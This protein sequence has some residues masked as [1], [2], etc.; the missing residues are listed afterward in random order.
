MRQVERCEIRI[1]SEQAKL[2]IQFYCLLET[3]KNALITIMDDDNLTAAVS[4][5]NTTNLLVILLIII[6]N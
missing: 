4:V 2:Q 5:E 1:L 3:I 6:R